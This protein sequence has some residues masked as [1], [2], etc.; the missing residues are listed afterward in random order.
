[1]CQFSNVTLL[2]LFLHI[3]WVHGLRLH[4][5]AAAVLRLSNGLAVF[6]EVDGTNEE[7]ATRAQPRR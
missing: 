7:K 3:H 5:A 2:L 1:M 4:N 6:A